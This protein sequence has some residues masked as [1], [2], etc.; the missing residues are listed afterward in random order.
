MPVIAG[1]S[2]GLL[3]QRVMP[4]YHDQCV[5]SLLR[6]VFDLVAPALLNSSGNYNM[7]TQKSKELRLT[8]IQEKNFDRSV[9]MSRLW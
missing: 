1:Q 6:S 9:Q 4:N 8:F 5:L 3:N 7:I 2:A